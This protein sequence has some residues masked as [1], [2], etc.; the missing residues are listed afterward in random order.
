MSYEDNNK[1]I[2]RNNPICP[3]CKQ[4]MFWDP[5]KKTWYCVYC[6]DD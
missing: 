4:E 1:E 2:K 3:E 6:D 5:D